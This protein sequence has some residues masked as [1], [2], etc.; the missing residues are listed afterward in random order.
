MRLIAYFTGRVK[1]IEI[2]G[3]LGL[4]TKKSKVTFLITFS[5]DQLLN[6]INVT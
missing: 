4:H 5:I 2:Q 6:K 1:I 3:L